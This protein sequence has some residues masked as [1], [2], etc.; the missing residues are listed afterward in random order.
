[1]ANLNFRED[2]EISSIGENQVKTFLESKGCS[3][4][5][6]NNDNKY[7][8]KMVKNDIE[9][10]Y[11]VKTDFKCAPLFDTGN[12]FIEFECRKH[13]SGVA[14]SQADWF[15]TYFLYLNELWF[16]KTENLRKLISDNDFQ[17]FINAG[18]LN[19]ETKGYLIN[20]KQFRRNFHV[21]KI[22]T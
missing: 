11:E 10:T 13:P 15:V 4:K 2:L 14:V 20:R 21:Y 19:S 3:F 12:I 5:S 7:D 6:F 16:I 1:M 18:D 17:I 22:Q 8:L 9:V